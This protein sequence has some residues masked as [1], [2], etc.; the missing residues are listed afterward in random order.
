MVYSNSYD[1]KC[2]LDTCGIY[3]T[4]TDTERGEIVCG[5]CGLVLLQKLEDTHDETR[6]TQ[7]EYMT[8]TRTGPATSLSMHDRGLSTRIGDN[9]DSTGNALSNKTKMTFS[10]LRMWDQRSKSK[11]IN[12]N[13]GSAFTILAGIKTKLAIPDSV[14]ENAAYIYRK[15]IAAKLARGRTIQSLVAASLYAACRETNTP[16]TLDDI[17]K[18]GNVEK[19][20]LSRDLRTIVK[21]L[22]LSLRQYDS[23]SFVVRV[24]NDLGIKEKTKRDAF[25]IMAKSQEKRISDGKNPIAHAVA[26]LYLACMLNNEKISQRKFSQESGISSVTIRNSIAIIRKALN[27]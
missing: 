23:N 14:I 20:I 22:D 12:R 4:V 19:K 16:R 27:L 26:C 21:T 5:S 2:K 25:D 11:S 8:Q 18:A 13:L 6:Y 7:E 17:S 1:I 10:R 15:V 24:S 3:P 9:K